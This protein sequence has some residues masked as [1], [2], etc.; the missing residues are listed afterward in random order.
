MQT[1]TIPVVVL[2]YGKFDLTKECLESLRAQTGVNVM[3][4]LV[5]GCSPD[6]TVTVLSEMAAL[7]DRHTFLEKNLGFAGGNNGALSELLNESYDCVLILNN[8]TVL[9]P[10]ALAEMYALLEKHPD[11]GQ[12]CP[13]LLYGDGRVQGAGGTIRKDLF[14]PGMI[15]NQDL[16]PSHYQIERTVEFA[17]GCA[18]LVRMT[19]LKK[20]GLIPEGYYMYSEDVDWS[21][22]FKKAGYEIWYTP[23]AVITHFESVASGVMSAFKGYYVVRG[24]VLLAK[25]WLSEKEYRIFVQRMRAKLLRQS[26]KYAKY[27]SYVLGM[28]KGFRAGLRHI[29]GPVDVG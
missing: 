15:G 2:Q 1:P 19:A 20:V 26:I 5:D 11:A 17:S 23:K 7:A 21:F 4:W 28:W 8:D 13:L 3:L 18:V 24:N 27:P 25:A 12:V 6:R 9:C 14:E 10:D 16:D 22:R 29:V